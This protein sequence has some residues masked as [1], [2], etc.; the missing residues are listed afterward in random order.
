[1]QTTYFF[2]KLEQIDT[3][4]KVMYIFSYDEIKHC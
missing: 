4:I 3:R 1:M 2:F